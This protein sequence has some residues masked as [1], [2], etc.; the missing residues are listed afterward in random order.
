MSDMTQTPKCELCGE[1]M[2]PGEEMFKFHGYSG[3]CPCPPLS[4][5]PEWTL[6][7]PEGKRFVGE[8]KWAAYRAEADS[9]ITS[10][11]QL[12]NI[13]RANAECEAEY[14]AELEQARK[15]AVAEYIAALEAADKQRQAPARKAIKEGFAV[16]PVALT[17]AMYEEGK[18]MLE[19]ML[20]A[21]VPIDMRI[22]Y[23][24]QVSVAL[25][26]SK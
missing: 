11:E 21:K 4:L 5:K 16:L 24:T 12:A 9:R 2:P 8:T 10:T 26:G 20:E 7:S 23:T 1:P 13:M 25:K 19:C 18:I 6:V 17:D 14:Q 3:G 15:D 22:I